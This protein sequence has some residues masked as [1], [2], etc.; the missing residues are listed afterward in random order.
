MFFVQKL[1]HTLKAQ[2]EHPLKRHAPLRSAL[3]FCTA[4]VAVRL[5]PG[6]IAVPFPNDTRLVVSPRMKGAAHFISPGL[7]EF[8]EMTFVTHFLRAGD[9]FADVGANV[10]AYSVLASGVAG[11]RSVAFEPSPATFRYLVD[12]IRINNLASLI[13]GL[14]VAVGRQEGALS[15]TA[16]LGTENYICPNGQ[17][18][19]GVQVRVTTLDQTFVDSIPR[20]I[21]VDVEGF[22]TEVFAGAERVLAHADLE[23]MIV[24]KGGLG[25]RYGYDEEP[26]HARI[27][28]A[29]FIPCTYEGLTRTLARSP[30][31]V[32][33]NII[34]VRDLEKVQGRLRSAPA[35]R[36]DGQSI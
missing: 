17:S 33:G 8:D 29:G 20:L 1:Y 34:Y 21:K 6:D 10:G 24:E 35:F 12:N 22:E 36:F 18:E 31:D 26:M 5:V 15:L 30:S 4:Q 28:R 27:Q 9:L 19:R 14:N 25:A 3:Q 11:A 7:C 16:N 13:T 2:A 23:A 32:R